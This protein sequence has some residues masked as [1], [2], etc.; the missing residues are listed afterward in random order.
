ML[1]RRPLFVRS[2]R[3]AAALGLLMAATAQAQPSGGPYGPVPQR[4]ALP[5]AAHVYFVAPN[6][7]ADATGASINAPTSIES[8]IARVVSGDAIVMR[9]GT[10]RTGGLQL[11]QG[12]TV[13]PYLDEVPVL[14]G[15]R[16]AT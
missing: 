14:K 12:I 5:Q 4:Y 6:G 8:A 7:K 11:N 3:W 1:P 15:T 10:Y 9:G 2:R 13:Q 16:V